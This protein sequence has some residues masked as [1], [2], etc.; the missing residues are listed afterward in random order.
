MKKLDRVLRV[1]RGLSALEEKVERLDKEVELM[2][3]AVCTLSKHH[4]GVAR[5][6]Y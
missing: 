3:N 2:G 6:Y 4:G 1:I 5:A